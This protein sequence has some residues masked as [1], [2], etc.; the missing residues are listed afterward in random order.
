MNLGI[1]NPPQP[2]FI[3]HS[4]FEELMGDANTILTLVHTSF[5]YEHPLVLPQFM[6]R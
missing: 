3:G 2:N 1:P 6:Q 5:S 4:L